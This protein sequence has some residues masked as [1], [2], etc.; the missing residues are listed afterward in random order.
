MHASGMAKPLQRVYGLIEHDVSEDAALIYKGE[1][2][3]FHD[4]CND[5][6][7]KRWLD[8]GWRFFGPAQKDTWPGWD[9]NEHTDD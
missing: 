7:S 9:D 3:D 1:R 6:T 5:T 2:L 4:I 8:P